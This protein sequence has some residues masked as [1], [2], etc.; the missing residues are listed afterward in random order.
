MKIIGIKIDRCYFKDNNKRTKQIQNNIIKMGGA[1]ILSVLLSLLIMPLTIDYVSP[2]LYGIWLT[3]N[4]TVAWLQVFDIGINNGLRNELTKSLAVNDIKGAKSLVST[5]YVSLIFIFLPL[6]FVLLL[7]TSFVDWGELLKVAIND[8]ILLSIRIVIIYFCL[9]FILSTINIILLSDQRAAEASY[10]GVIE[11]LIS[12]FTIFLLI[13]T[14]K[15]NLSFLAFALCIVPLV[16]L[17]FYNLFLFKTR[18]KQISPHWREANLKSAK[19]ILSLGVKF[20]VIQIA[21]VVLFQTSNFIIIRNFGPDEV[22]NHNIAYKYFSVLIMSMTIFNTPL[23]SAMTNAFVLKDYLWISKTVNKFLLISTV[24]GLL[25]VIMLFISP[26]VYRIWI[27]ELVDIPFSLSF[28]L[29]IYNLLSL[30]G[31]VYCGVLNG[32]GRL[33]IQ[34][35][36]SIFAPFIFVVSSFILINFFKLGAEALVYSLII[37]NFNAYILAP[38]EYYKFRKKCVL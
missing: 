6:L 30:Y 16:V 3:L 17:L 4:S 5:A 18:Y 32:I 11:Q 1:K 26:F 9:R 33:N 15:G 28:S 21:G 7:L 2:Q 35:I 36:A 19:H 34:F 12:F 20:F 38:I 29:F 24:F 25:G 31:G 22:T 27:G 23:W 10:R 8:D 13:K 14:T 37:A